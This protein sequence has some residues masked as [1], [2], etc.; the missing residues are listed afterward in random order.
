MIELRL[1]LD[2]SPWSAPIKG[3]YN[4]YD[5]KSKEK[6]FARW[7]IKSQ[8]KGPLLNCFISIEF[9]FF[10]PLQ[11]S[12]SK[13]DIKRKIDRELLPSTPDITNMQK[14]Y[15]DCLQG[16]VIEN[17]RLSNKIT[18]VR[19]YSERPG[20]EIKIRTWQEELNQKKETI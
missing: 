2:P 10:I 20:V 5:K 19:Y 12:C 11:K 1:D 7:Q 6:E 4:F 18:S 14:L 3:R 17:D 9:I 16:I 13:R 15:E 8:Y